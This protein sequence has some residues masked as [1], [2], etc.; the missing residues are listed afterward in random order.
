MFFDLY[1]LQNSPIGEFV[2]PWVFVFAMVYGLL[3][4]AGVFKANK[5]VNILVS[6]TI[7]FFSVATK[8]FRNFLWDVM[9]WAAGALI[10]LAFGKVAIDVIG[11]VPDAAKWDKFVNLGTFG[12]L[13]IFLGTIQNKFSSQYFDVNQVLWAIGFA[14][15]G[16]LIYSVMQKKEQE[17]KISQ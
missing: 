3:G 8:D 4:V 9:P 15:V 7:A 14:A 5:P 13:F 12:L 11:K 10:L 17:D 2:I 1:N 6:I 16:I